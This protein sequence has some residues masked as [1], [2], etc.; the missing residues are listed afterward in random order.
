MNIF[1][2]LVLSS[3]TDYKDKLISVLPLEQA[4]VMNTTVYR[5]VV[6]NNFQCLLHDV[7]LENPQGLSIIDHLKPHVSAI[8]FILDPSFIEED[9][10]ERK[11]LEGILSNVDIVPTV[12]ALNGGELPDERFRESGLYLSD[13]GR[14]IFWNESDR[15]SMLNVWQQLLVKLKAPE[16]KPAL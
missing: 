16:E 10:N 4:K 12:V 3:N 7:N 11:L 8:L 9:S 2:I 1:E 14:L 15:R 6:D 13:R 5:Y